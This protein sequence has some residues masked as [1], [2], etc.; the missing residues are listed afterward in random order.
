MTVESRIEKISDLM[1]TDS[2]LL[3][4]IEAL[5]SAY[6]SADDPYFELPEELKQK[7]QQSIEQV[8]SGE[9]T[10]HQTVLAEARTKYNPKE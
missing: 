7:L 3:N 2:R 6:E 1:K 9:V 5:V 8:E 4:L 10:P